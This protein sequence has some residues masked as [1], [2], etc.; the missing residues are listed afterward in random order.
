MMYKIEKI[1]EKEFIKYTKDIKH[2]SFVQTPEYTKIFSN[3]IFLGLYKENILKGVGIFIPRKTY[4]NFKYLYAPHGFICDYNDLELVEAFT[5]KLKEYA[6]LN[7]YFMLK[8]DP[9]IVINKYNNDIKLQ[10]T[11]YE[12]TINFLKKLG[13]DILKYSPQQN[14]VYVLKLDKDIDDIFKSFRPTVKNLIKRTYKYHMRI[15]DVKYEE[16][17]RFFAI[18]DE[19][20]NLKGFNSKDLEYYQNVYK[21]LKDKALFKM[22][23]VDLKETIKSLEK[24]KNDLEKLIA[25]LKDK[26]HKEKQYLD[27]L[28]KLEALNKT[29]LELVELRKKHGDNLDISSAL[30]IKGSDEIIYFFSGSKR[31]YM[32]FYGQYL[33]QWE[34]IKYAKENN[35]DYYNFYGISNNFDPNSKDYNVFKFKQGFN[36]QVHELLGECDLKVKKFYYIYKLIRKLRNGK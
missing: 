23:V 34:M 13:Y 31:E 32:F 14:F 24:E 7:N 19:T 4:F 10:E 2:R 5:I 36:G 16:L 33:L 8:I 27:E 29:L 18:I 17:E 28:S 21:N 1:E 22:A 25:T 35:F 9:Y 15:H 30:F 26:K 11:Y 6:S 20:S 12:K 3:R